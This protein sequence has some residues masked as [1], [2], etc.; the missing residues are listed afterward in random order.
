MLG[1]KVGNMMVIG[2]ILL[3]LAAALLVLGGLA[4]AQKLPGN[5]IVG[6]RVPEVR[7]SEDVWKAAHRVAGPLWV[8]GGVALALGGLVAIPATGWMWLIVALTVLAALVLL[9]MGATAGARTAA[10]L[11][12][13]AEAESGGCS[14]CSNGGGC[15]CG[16][17]DARPAPQVDLE[18][19]RR[20]A[21][22]SDA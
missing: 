1:V 3:V 12:V 16:G 11:D 19:A 21:E 5:G 9:G 22:A 10:I 2:V 6:I 18:A 20:A 7:K 4:W 14:S 17:H 13:R 15:G 8:V